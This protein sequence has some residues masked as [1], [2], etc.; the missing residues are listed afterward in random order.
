MT[1]TA[2]VRDPAPAARPVL[3]EALPASQLPLRHVFPCWEAGD[4]AVRQTLMKVR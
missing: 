1:R 3:D 4:G 2:D